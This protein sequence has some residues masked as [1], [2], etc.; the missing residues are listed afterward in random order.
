MPSLQL[1]TCHTPLTATP[2]SITVAVKSLEGR[3]LAIHITPLDSSRLIWVT[4]RLVPWMT[5]C[6]GFLL[7]DSQSPVVLCWDCWRGKLVR[8]TPLPVASF[9]PHSVPLPSCFTR[10][11]ES[12]WSMMVSAFSRSFYS[13][14]LPLR[15]CVEDSAVH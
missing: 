15:L 14:L 13:S 10:D 1:G 4:F 5:W 6:R 2:L 8:P 3:L 9:L 12:V 7:L 11:G